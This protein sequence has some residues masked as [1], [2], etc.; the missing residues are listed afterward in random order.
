[1]KMRYTKT[2]I[3]S[4]LTLLNDLELKGCENAKRVVLI[5]NILRNPI[6]EEKTDG[7]GGSE[8]HEITG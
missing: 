6:K 5:E 3:N 7:E 2:A 4:A 1:M 8:E